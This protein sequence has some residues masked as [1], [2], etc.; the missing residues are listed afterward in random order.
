MCGFEGLGSWWVAGSTDGVRCVGVRIQY[1][2]VF[3]WDEEVERVC[4]GEMVRWQDR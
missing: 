4:V 3:C 1:G 2:V